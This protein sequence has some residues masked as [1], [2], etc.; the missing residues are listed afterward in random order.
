MKAIALCSCGER[1][2]IECH[3]RLDVFSTVLD[4]K[5]GQESFPVAASFPA[6]KLKKPLEFL[7]GSR[8]K[9]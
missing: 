8:L 7:E 3:K 2:E 5:C 9:S 1:I 4:C 6:E